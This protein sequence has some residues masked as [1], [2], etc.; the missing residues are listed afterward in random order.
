MRLRWSGACAPGGLLASGF[1]VVAGRAGGDESATVDGLGAGASGR[2]DAV[3]VVRFGG[4]AGAAW[5]LELAAMAGVVEA[6]FA[7]SA[8]GAC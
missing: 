3:G 4:G 6:V 1:D 7:G 8:C 2:C 5:V